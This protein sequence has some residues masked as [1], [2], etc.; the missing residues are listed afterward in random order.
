MTDGPLVLFR[1][2]G[3][4]KVGLGHVVRCLALADELREVHGCQVAFAM[5]DGPLGLEMVSKKGYQVIGPPEPGHS[6]NYARWLL[7]LDRKGVPRVLVFDVRD[8]LARAD[9]DKLREKGILIVVVDDASERRL[10]ADFAFYPP[11]PQV[12]RLNWDGFTGQLFVGWDWVILRRE[13]AHSSRTPICYSPSAIRNSPLK[14]LVT[15]GGSD[16]NG[17]TLRTVKALDLLQEDFQTIVLL[18]PGF[19]HHDALRN[20]L[21]TMHRRF[22]VRENVSDVAV[23]MTQADLAVAS[24][25]VTAYE[26]AAMGVSAVYLC[27]TQDHA[28]SASPFVEAGMAICLGVSADVTEEMLAQKV[29]NLLRDVSG[30]LRMARQ[31]TMQVDGQGVRRVA[32]ILATRLSADER[33]Q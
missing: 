14:V 19:V 27:L 32:D 15:M 6:F 5:R 22:D 29:R 30:R 7:E 3:S 12:Q 16:P 28:E 8:D 21:A 2:D 9:V 26:L 11:V 17:L 4:Q 25:G 1:C 18:G 10:A 13:F 31:A 33:Q 24:F 20:Q 23:L